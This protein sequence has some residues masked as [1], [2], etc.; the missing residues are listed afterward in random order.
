[1]LL[2]VRQ[3]SRKLNKEYQTVNRILRTHRPAISPVVP[4]GG[5][6]T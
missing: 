5:K 2:K 6:G 3:A 4:Q 1:L